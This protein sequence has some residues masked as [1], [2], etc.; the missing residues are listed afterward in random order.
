MPFEGAIGWVFDGR[1]SVI[2][3]H[4]EPLPKQAAPVM[5]VHFLPS[6][7]AFALFDDGHP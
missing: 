5:L 7:G 3:L 6:L 1:V 2:L 4:H